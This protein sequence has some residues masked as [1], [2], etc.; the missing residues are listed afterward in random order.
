MKDVKI[1]AVYLAAGQSRR[2]GENKLALPLGAKTV[3]SLSLQSALKSDL[4][5]III[6]AK[7]DD[8][9]E[10]VAPS[11][12]QNPFK[13]KWSLVRCQDAVLG[14]AHSLKCGLKA[15]QELNPD[16]IMILLADN[17]F[18]DVKTI[19]DVLLLGKQVQ[20]KKNLGQISFVGASFQGI[21]RPPIL[22]FQQSFP[23]LLELKGDQGARQL[24][25]KSLLKGL[26]LDVRDESIFID[27]DTKE[28]YVKAINRTFK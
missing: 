18:L 11:L 3:G 15:A 20:E 16:G 19:N 7:E 27:L 8:R 9:L 24:L 2:M 14:Q 4:D 13:E 22:F 26:L 28:D 12:F 21:P 25:R 23:Y 17:P 6:V 5:H 1:C 10:W